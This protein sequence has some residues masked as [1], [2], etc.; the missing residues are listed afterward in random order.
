MNSE[1]LRGAKAKLLST[2]ADG[3]KIE[4]VPSKK[5]LF[6]KAVILI[7]KQFL[8]QEVKYFVGSKPKKTVEFK[9]YSQVGT[10]WRPRTLV[11]HK[12]HQ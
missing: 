11:I 6:T 2:Q 4:V 10:I 5:A 9:D 3:Y 8:P 7:S 12:P 1:I